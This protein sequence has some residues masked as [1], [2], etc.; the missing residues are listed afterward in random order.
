VTEEEREEGLA[1]EEVGGLHGAGLHGAGEQGARKQVGEGRTTTCSALIDPQKVVVSSAVNAA[2]NAAVD[3]EDAFI[4]AATADLGMPL[5][6]GSLAVAGS[7]GGEGDLG[8]STTCAFADIYDEVPRILY[9][10]DEEEEEDLE[11][12]EDAEYSTLN[13]TGELTTCGRDGMGSVGGDVGAAAGTGTPLR[14]AGFDLGL[15]LAEQGEEDEE[16]EGEESWELSDRARM[17]VPE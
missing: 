8:G 7:G 4:G 16:D 9:E 17:C 15:R 12:N 14:M 11:A 1:A 5:G 10:P 2:V 13:D 6:R 3:A